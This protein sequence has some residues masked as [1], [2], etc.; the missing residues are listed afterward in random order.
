[1]KIDESVES[2]HDAVLSGLMSAQVDAM[3]YAG[4]LGYLFA[5]QDVQERLLDTSAGAFVQSLIQDTIAMAAM[6]VVRTVERHLDDP[7]SLELLARRPSGEALLARVRAFREDRRVGSLRVFRTEVVAHDLWRTGSRDRRRFEKTFGEYEAVEYLEL[8]PLSKE[9]AIL[10]DAARQLAGCA[11]VDIEYQVRR[12]SEEAE[13]F[14][15][16]IPEAAE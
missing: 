2:S 12:Y 10:C 8:V 4:H 15:D 11:A 1:M 5:N 14:W 9:L 3:R 6:H 7:T 16:L 13:A